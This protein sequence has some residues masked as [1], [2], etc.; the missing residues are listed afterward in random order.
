MNTVDRYPNRHGHRTIEQYLPFCKGTGT[1]HDHPR[2]TIV[3]L[4]KVP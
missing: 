3:L 4:L 1:I 2:K